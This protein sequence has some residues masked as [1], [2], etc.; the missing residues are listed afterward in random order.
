MR[1]IYLILLIIFFICYNS[2]GQFNNPKLKYIVQNELNLQDITLGE[3]LSIISQE[4]SI[5]IVPSDEI[6]NIVIDTYFPSNTNLEDILNTFIKLYNLKLYKSGDIFILVKRSENSN[7]IFSGRVKSE[8]SGKGLEGVKIT[9]IDSFTQPVFSTYDGNFILSDI[10]PA[11]YIA[12]F[13]KEGY[14]HSTTLID[15]TE[16]NVSIDVS[17]E[18][19]NN[20]RM[21]KE[22]LPERDFSSNN[23]INYE[24]IITENIF[25]YNNNCEDI[26]KLLL[27]SFGNALKVSSL[28]KK[29]ILV[30]SGKYQAIKSVKSLI[31][32]LDKDIE[33]IR[34]DAQILDVTNNLFETLGFNWMFDS[35]ENLSGSSEWSATLL[36][37]S[38]IAGIGN[39]FSS[40]IGIT[41]QFNS[42][43]DVLDMSINLLE[44]TQDLVVTA[45][46]SI[47]VLDREEGSFKVTEEVIVGE[48]REEND[49]NDRVISTPI[50]R[51]AGIILNVTP[52]I[53]RD[54]WILLKVKIEVS[55]FK[56]KIN[57]DETESG[58]TY[59]SEGGSKV[60]RTI[61]TSIKIRDGETIFIGGLKKATSSNSNSQIPFFGTLPMINFFFKNESTSHEV[62]DIYIRMK[63]N[64]VNNEKNSFENKQIDQRAKDI[65]NR[66]I[67]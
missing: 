60:G 54:G 63:V 18:R 65:M 30:V 22:T 43:S 49:N 62:T 58:G 27:E 44:A 23:R 8:T 66:K 51:E 12:R 48:K 45:R 24:E 17:L 61:E 15:L 53:T 3:T 52:T 64:I 37:T 55:N 59:N 50:F 20:F 10:D 26:E 1:K 5:P 13:E 14:H 16:K 25:L 36:G 56:L 32:E 34:I 42:K 11:V 31:K 41:K 57:K 6:R 39:V 4:S 28:P 29:N 38:S 21:K 19:D 33:Q 9:L 40:T 7:Y 35:S 2:Y 46:P 47:L 67:Y